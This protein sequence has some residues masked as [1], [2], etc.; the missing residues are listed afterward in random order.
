MQQP[1]GNWGPQGY[2]PPPS[3]PSQ[4]GYP[5]PSAPYGYPPP[6]PPPPQPTGWEGSKTL[7]TAI[8]GCLGLVVIVVLGPWVGCAAC[9]CI[10]AAGNAVSEPT[11]SSPPT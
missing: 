8:V 3:Q 10:G 9:A 6:A 7:V 4:Q 5:P 11:R 2:G 1:P